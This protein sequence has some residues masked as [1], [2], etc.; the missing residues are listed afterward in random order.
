MKKILEEEVT[1]FPIILK[2]KILI[3]KCL[4]NKNNKINFKER[5]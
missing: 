2:L 4:I 5:K 3:L 1:R